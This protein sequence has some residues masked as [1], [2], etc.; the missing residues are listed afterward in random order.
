[1]RIL[2]VIVLLYSLII[3]LLLFFYLIVIITTPFN[4]NNNNSFININD[5]NL[6]NK[7]A[8]IKELDNNNIN[9]ILLLLNT[10][11]KTI[12]EEDKEDNR[13]KL[14]LKPKKTKK[15]I[16]TLIIK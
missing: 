9:L 2:I 11:F 14:S 13:P 5:F 7:G 16:I 8:N 12:K 1:V 3:F 15:R 6:N 10:S 4:N